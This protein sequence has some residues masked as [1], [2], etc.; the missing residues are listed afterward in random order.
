MADSRVTTAISHW[1]PRFIANGIDYNDFVRVTASI[2]H[3]ES[4]CEQWCQAGSEHEKLGRIAL[5]EGR[6][7]SAG[8]HLAQASV[9]Y[10]FAKFLFV[11]DL[12]QLRAAHSLAVE[13]LTDALP[14][15]DPP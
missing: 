11:D 9:Y 14:F 12:S 2:E 1:A 6:T 13:C 15:L 4:W 8:S 7:R 3:W 5:D 10:H